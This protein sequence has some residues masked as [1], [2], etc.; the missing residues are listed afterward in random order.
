MPYALDLDTL[1]IGTIVVAVD[2]W[3]ENPTPYCVIERATHHIVGQTAA[4]RATYIGDALV[5]RMAKPAE[6][7][8]FAPPVRP[9]PLSSKPAAQMDLFA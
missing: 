5:S 8:A 2:C 9:A 3:G 1:P 4:G 7:A 6:A